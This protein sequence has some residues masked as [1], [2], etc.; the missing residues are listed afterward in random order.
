M[1]VSKTQQLRHNIEFWNTLP[2]CLVGRINAI[3]VVTLP[4]FL[5]MFQCLPAYKPLYYFKK[6]DSTIS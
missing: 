3:K 4:R 2:I 1:K 5:Y 6:L